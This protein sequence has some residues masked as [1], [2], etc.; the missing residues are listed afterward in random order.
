MSTTTGCLCGIIV[1]LA[2]FSLLAPGQAAAEGEAACATSQCHPSLI[3]KKD[4][5]P[6]GHE[7]C[8]HCHQQTDETK[9]HPGSGE[10]SFTL[11]KDLCQE[12]HQAIVDYPYLHP[13]VAAGDCLICHTFHSSTPSLLVDSKDHLL[14]YNCHKPVINEGDTVLHG[15][16][17]KKCSSC[18]TVHG[19]FFNHLLTGPYST[20]FFNDYDEKHYALCFQC[21]KIDLLLHPKTSYN[22][23]FRNGQQN[24]H[25]V[26]VNRKSRGRSCKLCHVVHSGKQE[27]L[28]AEKVSFGDWEMPINFVSTANGGQCAPG[29][30]APASYDRNRATSQSLPAP[31]PPPETEALEK[32]KQ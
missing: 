29:C 18:H 32:L 26:H 1:L 13:P 12:C 16:I 27:K 20:D 9:K 3:A 19:S 31:S 10:N 30:H 7:D 2:S 11:A 14:C 8:G 15:D 4:A 21:H 6:K 24:L 25:F 17:D 23:N 28:M 22:T 5:L